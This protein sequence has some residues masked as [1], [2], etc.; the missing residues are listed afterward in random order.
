MAWTIGG[1]GITLSAP[2]IMFW[3]I[4]QFPDGILP[5]ARGFNHEYINAM[6][7]VVLLAQSL[8]FGAIIATV[9]WLILRA[10]RKVPPRWLLLATF[11]WASGCLGGMGIAT[12]LPFLPAPVMFAL[13]L[14][15][16]GAVSAWVTWPLLQPYLASRKQ[17]LL[18]NTWGWTF[19]GVI[20]TSLAV[21]RF[22]D[23][24]S[25]WWAFAFISCF[26]GTTGSIVTAWCFS[27]G[28]AQM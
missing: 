14:M 7:A 11:G 12:L 8:C 16:G 23:L 6:V 13:I 10:W 4:T 26:A 5:S 2:Y 27:H 24:W 20:I 25:L 21:G 22:G 19:G 3:F 28:E 9:Q 17:W 18:C 15:G 1:I